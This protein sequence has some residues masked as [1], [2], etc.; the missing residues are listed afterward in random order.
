MRLWGPKRPDISTI[1]RVNDRIRLEVRRNLYMSRVEDV[2][3][4]EL[5]AAAPLDHDGIVDVS[6]GDNV[7]IDVF[8]ES[9]LQRFG[10][11]VKRKLT[12]RIPLL[13]LSEFQDL[14][15]TQNRQ[16]VRVDAQLSVRYRTDADPLR[17]SLWQPSMTF[18]ISGGGMQM[19]RSYKVKLSEGDFVEAE[20]CIPGEKSI[21]AVARI[22]RTTVTCDNVP[23]VGAEFVEIQPDD[24]RRI[25]QFVRQRELAHAEHRKV[26]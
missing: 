8:L 12:D 9:A 15:I 6:P 19:S 22:V 21:F 14:G 24:R 7:I 3:P 20:I 11:V 13:G 16:Y 17:P 10:S 18:D 4:Q 25:V 26:A 23:R 2:C 5:L 1:V